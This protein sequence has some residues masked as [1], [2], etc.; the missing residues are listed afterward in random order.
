[1]RSKERVGVEEQWIKS[2]H[3]PRPSGWWGMTGGEERAL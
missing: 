2:N 3:R 1:M